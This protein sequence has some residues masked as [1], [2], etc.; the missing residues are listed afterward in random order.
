[1]NDIKVNYNSKRFDIFFD[2]YVSLSDDELNELKNKI[3]F[4]LK[5]INNELKEMIALNVYSKKDLINL[6]N[7]KEE[8]LYILESLKE[9]DRTRGF[10]DN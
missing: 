1:M 4:L 9:I 7:K 5:E 6:R 3:V 2:K 8:N 10:K